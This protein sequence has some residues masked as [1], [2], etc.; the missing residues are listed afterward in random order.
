MQV[1]GKQIYPIIIA[2]DT[3]PDDEMAGEKLDS[4]LTDGRS[5]E[6]CRRSDMT[7]L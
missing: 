2:Q 3:W 4:A 1:V 6:L 7:S 5:R